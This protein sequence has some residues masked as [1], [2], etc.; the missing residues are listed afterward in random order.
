M[1]K[2]IKRYKRSSRRDLIV[3]VRDLKVMA[4]DL[5]VLAKKDL[6]A[7]SKIL[8]WVD[9]RWVTNWWGPVVSE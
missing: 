9:S 5:S 1:D 8:L 2:P 6:N 3:K 4:R 7:E